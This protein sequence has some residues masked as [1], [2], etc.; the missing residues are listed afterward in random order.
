MF[1]S[2]NV[3]FIE[4]HK[5]GCTHIGKLLSS[6]MEGRQIGKHNPATPELFRD[7]RYFLGSIRNPWEWYVSLWSYGCDKKGGL[8]ES[9]TRGRGTLRGLG[10]RSNPWGAALVLAA[11]LSRE[12]DTW[13]QCY[14]DV[15]DASQFRNW[16]YM[17]HDKSYWPHFGEGYASSR[18]K[19]F[20][21]FLTF[22]YLKLFCR[23]DL[24]E[25]RSFRALRDFAGTNCYIDH[26]IRNE[27][28]E[29]DLIGALDSCGVRLSENQRDRI[30]SSGRTNASSR[31]QNASYY[32]DDDTIALVY[33]RERFIVDKFGYVPPTA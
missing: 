6:L 26:F 33:E 13:K 15:H 21:G 2:G 19:T 7:R 12:P 4:L 11:D 28:L 24:K 10:W 27:R 20:A 32:Y 30:R 17:M 18:L 16:L 9:V 31:K 5:T 3:V 29:E 23:R 1:V 8:Y 22:R 14:A 25:V